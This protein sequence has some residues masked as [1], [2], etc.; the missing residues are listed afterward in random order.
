MRT[1]HCPGGTQ[2]EH[3]AP[4]GLALQNVPG[5]TNMSSLPG[6]DAAS[7]TRPWR[8][9]SGLVPSTTAG[10]PTLLSAGAA[11]GA[12]TPAGMPAL[13]AGGS[14]KSPMSAGQPPSSPRQL[15]DIGGESVRTH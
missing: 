15:I 14:S 1:A 13:R 4:T 6:L 3:A 11:E 7:G 10:A 2:A 9:R 5:S 8:Q 12:S